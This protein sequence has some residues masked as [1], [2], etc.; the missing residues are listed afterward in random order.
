[1][2]QSEDGRKG[3][4]GENQSIRDSWGPHLI[5]FCVF[6]QR[7]KRWKKKKSLEV[8][9]T[10][11]SSSLILHNLLKMFARYLSVCLSLFLFI[12][13]RDES[14]PECGGTVAQRPL[15]RLST[16]LTPMGERS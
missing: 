13:V 10:P 6:L 8:P 11:V 12:H 16:Q 9:V 7:K 5:S 4:G 15:R 2:L 3:E 14:R 1:M